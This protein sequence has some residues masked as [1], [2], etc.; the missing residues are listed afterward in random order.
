M[1]ILFGL[2]ALMGGICLLYFWLVAHWFARVLVFLMLAGV[3]CAV[4]L[5]S[6]GAASAGI[7]VIGV[8]LAW[9]IASIP[10]W[11]ARKRLE[12]ADATFVVPYPR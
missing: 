2:A 11:G 6:Y 4:G 9:V 12:K 8:P 10:T 7:L 1:G 5:V 3:V